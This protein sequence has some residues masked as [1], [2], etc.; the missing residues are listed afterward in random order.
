MSFAYRQG[1][2]KT[3][4]QHNG[5]RS[6]DDDSDFFGDDD[7]DDDSSYNGGGRIV[8]KAS[9]NDSSCRVNSER[10]RADNRK[11][12]GGKM[13][14]SIK[15]HEGSISLYSDECLAVHGLYDAFYSRNGWC[16]TITYLLVFLAFGTLFLYLTVP[17]VLS[18]RQRNVVTHV[19]FQ[20]NRNEVLTGLP[21]PILTVCPRGS[22]TRCDCPLWRRLYC[23]Y[24]IDVPN[25]AW[26]ERFVELACIDEVTFTFNNPVWD[27]AQCDQLDPA[28]PDFCEPTPERIEALPHLQHMT[29]DALFERVVEREK[30]DS[31]GPFLTLEEVASYARLRIDNDLTFFRRLEGSVVERV[32][33]SWINRDYFDPARG[34]MCVQA[35]PPFAEARQNSPGATQGLSALVTNVRETQRFSMRDVGFVSKAVDV[36]VSVI[37]VQDYNQSLLPIETQDYFP[38]Q[39]GYFTDITY[40][41]QA[42]I[43]TKGFGR[44]S[45]KLCTDTDGALPR[46][47]CIQTIAYNEGATRCGCPSESIVPADFLAAAGYA[48]GANF[49]A[50]SATTG[51]Q[52]STCFNDAI[53]NVTR[54]SVSYAECPELCDSIEP[55]IRTRSEIQTTPL[56]EAYLNIVYTYLTNSSNDVINN[57]SQR[58]NIDEV[59]VLSVGLDTLCKGKTKKCVPFLHSCCLLQTST[60]TFSRCC[61]WCWC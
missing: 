56:Q 47:T 31:D 4:E 59:V 46:S 55:V 45:S 57:V 30:N 24:S 9:T 7:D 58:L 38:V 42:K 2:H 22:G 20:E 34:Q 32:P 6:K 12:W 8:R 21:L 17:Q 60:L 40:E 18:Y 10:T 44:E 29:G 50:C 5:R 35:R 49:A 52:Q 39:A 54:S 26:R 51:T 36:H 48:D 23:R 25:D 3:E 19:S 27:N 33:E 28:E 15:D 43:R 14:D 61:C 41:I 37:Q 1:R 11:I 13:I 53:A 16:R